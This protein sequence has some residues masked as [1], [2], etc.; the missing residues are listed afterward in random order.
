MSIWSMVLREVVYRKLNFLLGLVG[1]SAAIALLVGV[2]TGLQLHVVRSD[3]L[4]S[5]KEEETKAVTGFVPVSLAGRR[6]G[7]GGSW[8]RTRLGGRRA[9]ARRARRS[10]RRRGRASVVALG[11]HRRGHRCAVGCRGRLDSGL[12]RRAAGPR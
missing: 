3:E 11:H 5:R 4:V 10:A 2:L 12:T 1:I 7:R 6:R 9:V 8:L